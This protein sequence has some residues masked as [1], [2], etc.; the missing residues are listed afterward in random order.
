MGRPREFDVERALDRALD[1]F[2]RNGYEGASIA[3][4][5]AAMGIN[6]PSLYAA[7]GNKEGLFLAALE[8]TYI[9][10]PVVA[11][12]KRI[13]V[14]LSDGTELV[15]PTIAPPHGLASNVRFY[16]RLM[17]CKSVRVRHIVGVDAGGRTVASIQ[18]RP[19]GPRITC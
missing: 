2:W 5:T 10:G 9:V 19:L 18:L 4:L 13:V 15:I 6:P 12:A 7:F 14:S 17:P 3:D 16:V 8:A 1:V 11:R